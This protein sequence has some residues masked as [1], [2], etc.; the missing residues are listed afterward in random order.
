MSTFDHLFL[1]EY[2]RNPTVFGL[3]RPG[4]SALPQPSRSHACGQV[5]AGG[6]TRTDPAE[7]RVPSLEREECQSGCLPPGERIS[8]YHRRGAMSIAS[9]FYIFTDYLRAPMGPSWG[10]SGAT[11]GAMD[12]G[13][14]G[15]C[16]RSCH[17]SPKEDRESAADHPYAGREAPAWPDSFAE[18]LDWMALHSKLG[19]STEQD[20]SAQRCLPRRSA[21]AKPWSD[22]PAEPGLRGHLSVCPAPVL[23]PGAWDWLMPTR[24]SGLESRSPRSRWR[25]VLPAGCWPTPHPAQRGSQR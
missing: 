3:N 7:D 5:P 21:Q 20:Y 1:P 9:K 6:R 15:F 12:P 16:G 23:V 2:P 24:P 22:R 10:R 19:P 8:V 11:A 17:D 18:R 25:S 14:L 13:E 4:R